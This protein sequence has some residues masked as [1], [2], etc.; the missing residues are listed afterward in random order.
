MKNHEGGKREYIR[1]SKAYYAR[2]L[3]EPVSITIGIYYAEGG[4]SGEFEIEFIE[5]GNSS[6]LTARLKVFEDS[7]SALLLF[8]D[9]LEKMAEIDGEEIQEPEFCKLLDS[10]G[11]VDAT[12]YENKNVNN[13]LEVIKKIPQ[14]GQVQYDLNRQ[15]H[16]L[17]VAANKLGLYDAA[18]FIKL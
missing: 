14:Q 3:N 11:I 7:W 5:I 16:E 1:N 2:T 10:L 13:V 12:K 9:L 15:L 8:T 4:T 18:D 17:R 6:K